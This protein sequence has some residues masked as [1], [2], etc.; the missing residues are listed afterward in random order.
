[1]NSLNNLDEVP[2]D[3]LYQQ[4]YQEMRRY[5]DYQMVVLGWYATLAIG[6]IAGLFAIPNLNVNVGE[7]F[8]WPFS[9][10]FVLAGLCISYVIWYAH[11]R[12][13]SL[14][15]IANQIYPVS[16]P[17]RLFKPHHML[18]LII[19]MLTVAGVVVAFIIT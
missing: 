9:I 18:I 6:V 8:A 10:F 17:K 2:K 19:L 14:R 16:L 3:V 4:L 15:E 13:S 12:C 5:R 7:C 11:D 1:M